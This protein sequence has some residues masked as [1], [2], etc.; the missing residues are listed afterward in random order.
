MGGR[1]LCPVCGRELAL[2]VNSFY[3]SA[4]GRTFARH[5]E[6]ADPP[7]P[8]ESVILNV[9]SPVAVG[10]AQASTMTHCPTCATPMAR[11][12]TSY[13]C[14]QCGKTYPRESD[15]E[16]SG[17]TTPHERNQWGAGAVAAPRSPLTQNTTPGSQNNAH[18]PSV[19]PKVRSSSAPT[20]TDLQTL[21]LGVLLVIV[22]I[23][24][25]AQTEQ[26][27]TEYIGQYCIETVYTY[28]G[29][30]APVVKGLLIVA[31]IL[32]V[33]VVGF[34]LVSRNTQQK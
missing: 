13:Y 11:Q 4:C 23:A 20:R 1:P 9:A 26:C 18:A 22:G 5:S 31:G 16:G 15:R 2:Q 19:L 27:T 32:C 33:V 29:V 25:P 30:S 7:M 34:L 12:V 28:N 17:D 10:L 6:P 14:P 24:L 8:A 3:C 21:G